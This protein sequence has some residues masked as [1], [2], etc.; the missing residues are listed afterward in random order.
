MELAMSQLRV[1]LPV[2]HRLP[3]DRQRGSQPSAVWCVC[4]CG[5]RG[6]RADIDRSGEIDIDRKP[7]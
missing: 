4:A 5:P 7:E 2:G 3:S 1:L 6:M